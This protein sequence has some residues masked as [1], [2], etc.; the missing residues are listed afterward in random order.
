MEVAGEA[1]C[2]P[3]VV[4]STDEIALRRLLTVP[5]RDE[6]E[7]ATGP[8]FERPCR[9]VRR[10]PAE[11]AWAVAGQIVRPPRIPDSRKQAIS[12][13]DAHRCTQMRVCL[14]SDPTEPGRTAVA[15]GP[16][17]PLGPSACIGVH[18][19]LNHFYLWLSASRVRKRSDAENLAAARSHLTEKRPAI[20]Q[21]P[22]GPGRS[23]LP[24]GEAATAGTAIPPRP[25]IRRPA[26]PQIPARS[27]RQS[28]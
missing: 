10:T 25:P 23:C 14:L 2:P 28:L 19:W 6:R 15:A 17:V 16:V 27:G 11:P 5:S 12:T 8:D 26:P 24:G 4:S 3:S 20:L 22:V 1:A 13:T 9:K 21:A 18:L 7:T